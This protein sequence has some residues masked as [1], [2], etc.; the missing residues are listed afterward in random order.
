VE[1]FLDICH[2]LFASVMENTIAEF[3]FK[4]TLQNFIDESAECID[5]RLRDEKQNQLLWDAGK[6]GDIYFSH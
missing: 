3:E 2:Q 4:A 1:R 6:Q 5:K